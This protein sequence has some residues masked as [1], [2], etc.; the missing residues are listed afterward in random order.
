M[1]I[2]RSISTQDHLYF[3]TFIFSLNLVHGIFS[4][5]NQRKASSAQQKPFVWVMLF[6]CTLGI[7]LNFVLEGMLVILYILDLL[8]RVSPIESSKQ[9]YIYPGSFGGTTS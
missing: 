2:M 5:A 1:L 7:M 9:A 8:K 4:I 6:K 3:L